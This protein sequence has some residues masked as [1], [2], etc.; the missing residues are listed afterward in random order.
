MNDLELRAY[1]WAL[2][3][4]YKS[5]AATYAR[6]LAKYIKKT[7]VVGMDELIKTAKKKT[8]GE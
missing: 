7:S 3:Q 2:H 5:V 4:E 6:V 1:K 8:K